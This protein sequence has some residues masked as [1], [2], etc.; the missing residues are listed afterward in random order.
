MMAT[1]EIKQLVASKA[2]EMVQPDTT[3]GLGSGSTMYWFIYSLAEQVQSGLTIKAVPTSK[4]TEKLARKLGIPLTNLNNVPY[5]DLTIDGADEIDPKLNLIKGGGG[6]L[7][8]EKL[9]AVASRQ[10]IVIADYTKLVDRLGAFPLPLEVI[11]YGYKQVQRRIEQLYDIKVTLRKDGHRRFVTDHG[12]N[13]LDCHFRSITD[14]LSLNQE[15]NMIPGVVETGL[16]IDR[17]EMALIGY[18]DGS[19]KMIYR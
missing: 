16:F 14:M 7:L 19:T 2:I 15:L 1:T 10:M 11:P 3:I 18:R 5:V 9:V 8:Q 17:A 13:I 6:A 4:E 12:H